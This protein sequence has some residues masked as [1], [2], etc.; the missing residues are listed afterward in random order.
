MMRRISLLFCAL[1]LTLALSGCWASDEVNDEKDFWEDPSADHTQEEIDTSATPITSFAL[2][3]LQNVTF[4]PITCPD[5]MQQTVGALLYEG[6]FTLDESFTPQNVLCSRYEHNDGYTSY[7]FYLRESVCF[8]DG[9]ALTANDVLAAYRRAQTSERYSARFA[10]VASMRVSNGA[11]VITLSQGNSAFP[12]LLD[13][14]IVRSGSENNTVP[15]G[16]GPYLFVTDSDGA[17]L[18]R[19]ADWWQDTRLPFKRIELREVKDDDNK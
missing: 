13:I 11:L 2:P 17:C 1:T 6:L 14:P 3:Y 4:D 10:S 12:A 5:G 7:T 15:L 19:S 16:T 9:S 18:K 8:S